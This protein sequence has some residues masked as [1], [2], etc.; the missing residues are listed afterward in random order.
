MYVATSKVVGKVSVKVY[1]DTKHFRDNLEKFLNRWE[2]KQK[3]TIKVNTE[4]NEKQLK[5]EAK[6]KL[7]QLNK[8][9]KAE[10]RKIQF[11][12]EI[13]EVG[14][15]GSVKSA[16]KNLQKQASAWSKAHPIKFA[17]ELDVIGVDVDKAAM[18]AVE[19]KLKDWVNDLTPLKVGIAPELILGTSAYVTARLTYL[20]RPR[21]VA[22][23]PVLNGL[24]V[25]KVATVL[26]AL[27][28]GRAVWN[29]G[30]SLISG[31]K[32]LDKA[33]PKIAAVSTALINLAGY[34]MAAGSNIVSLG[35]SLASIAPVVLTLPGIFGGIAVG[36]GA[37]YAA[38][39]DINTVLPEVADQFHEMQDVI[40]ARFW[41]QAEAPMRR[42]FGTMMPLFTRNLGNTGDALGTF[43]AQLSDS[44][45]GGFDNDIDSMF[46]SLNESIQISSTYTEHF[47]GVIATLGRVGSASLPR[48]AEWFGDTAESFDGWL[49]KAEKDGR[50]Q[51]WIDTG[52]VALSD[53]GVVLRETG[54]TLAGLYR[55]MERAGGSTLSMLADTME[56]VSDT[57]NAPKFQ[58]AMTRAFR[59]AHEAMSEIA[60][61]SGP[62]FEGLMVRLS[63]VLSDNLPTAGRIAGKALGAVFG[64]LDQ[65][66]VQGAVTGFFDKIEEAVDNLAPAMPELARAL[67]SV[68]DVIGTVAVSISKVLAPVIEDLGPKVEEVANIIEPFAEFLGDV[69]GGA[70]SGLTGLLSKLP[71]ELLL[72]GGALLAMRRSSFSMSEG[73]GVVSSQVTKARAGITTF[74]GHIRGFGGDLRKMSGEYGRVNRVQSVMLSGLSNTTGA[75][76]RTRA[77]MGKLTMGAGGIAALAAVSSGAADNMGLSNTAMMGMMG[78]MAGPWGAAVGAGIGLVMDMSSAFSG[79]TESL[80]AA[81]E[82]MA[83]TSVSLADKFKSVETA[84]NGVYDTVQDMSDTTGVGDFFNDMIPTLSYATDEL[85]GFNSELDKG[86]D[87][88]WE[89]SGQVGGLANALNIASEQMGQGGLS[90]FDEF[91]DIDD[92]KESVDLFGA[93]LAEVQRTLTQL[94]PAMEYLGYTTEDLMDAFGDPNP[95]ALNDKMAEIVATSQRLDSVAGR[96]ELVSKAFQDLGSSGDTAAMSAQGLDAA[97][98][99]LLNPQ[100]NATQAAIQWREALRGLNGEIKDTQDINGFTAAADENKQSL[101][102][103]VQNLQSVITTNAAAG[104]GQRQLTRRLEEGRQAIIDQSA[105][106]REGRQ[107]VR[108]FLTTMGLTPKLIKSTLEVAGVDLSTKKLRD[109]RKIAQG[110][111]R[112]LQ[113]LVETKGFPG[114]RKQLKTLVDLYDEYPEDVTAILNVQSDKALRRTQDLDEQ[115]EALTDG[116]WVSEV[117]IKDN[118]TGTRKKAKDD[119]VDID[120]FF[121]RPSMDVTDRASPILNIVTQKLDNID[122]RTANSY[123]YTHY[124]T[125]GTPRGPSGDP[126][127]ERTLPT[128]S[129]SVA[130]TQ[131]ALR[132]VENMFTRF[133]DMVR[134]Q[135]VAASNKWMNKMRQKANQVNNA[136]ANKIEQARN[137]LQNADT[138]EERA[139]A[140]RRLRAL[141]K[142]AQGWRDQGKEIDKAV[143]KYE[144]VNQK[145]QEAVAKLDALKQ[146]IAAYKDALKSSFEGWASILNAPMATFSS[147]VNH[148]KRRILDLQEFKDGMADL[149][150]MGLDQT[151]ID[152]LAQ[153]GPDAL[154]FIQSIL[155]QGQAGVDELNDLWGQVDDISLGASD[156][157]GDYQFADELQSAEDAVDS[158]LHTLQDLQGPINAAANALL[159]NIAKGA[160]RNRREIVKNVD[161]IIKK[162]E[163]LLQMM[164]QATQQNTPG[165]HRMVTQTAKST[166]AIH[167]DNRTFHININSQGRRDPDL[168]A[169]AQSVK[170]VIASA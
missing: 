152:Q 46:S 14:L 155:A 134:N 10:G 66:R 137:R 70:V 43:F 82:A 76:Q 95:Q 45:T 160:K 88:V 77:A 97:L 7:L 71:P 103:M 136:I 38:L 141:Q 18:T 162:Y 6:R 126:T 89:L 61:H 150:S 68:V 98:S 11:Q 52:I 151:V 65:T 72:V 15:S 25:T 144:R 105:S 148:L 149:T 106:T 115:L 60:N 117:E 87:K 163:H 58:S 48:L 132:A 3:L 81:D 1:P 92:P 142:L 29:M 80:D 2:S 118:S 96:T 146:E 41:A 93:N 40:S 147:M 161:R 84:V 54:S 4:V 91:M 44:F 166:G 47:A 169:A 145:L 34:A 53:L 56:S 157:L 111:P 33:V 114:T 128:P 120:R 86:A 165:S 12:A 138:K 23:S 121:A 75:A 125:T 167:N 50:L 94:T 112:K 116:A 69:L 20:T 64:A 159:N 73:M 36:M 63:D 67:A 154:A 51:G 130:E 62:E 31:L 108:E 39:K 21:T 156:L 57:V 99:A 113:T 74:G 123:V 78:L 170:A 164:N 30:D 100:M 9:L 124:R 26:A 83:D 101:I 135:L 104:E 107:A 129:K 90:F 22:I 139:A 24:A 143:K 28:G 153:A 168:F 35:G 109:F 131:K 127:S 17:G 158:F 79:M 59:G 133:S 140:K 37:T 19:R 32:D 27:S 122:G 119:L 110:L 102:G 8:T 55:A 85:L 5:L 16:R 13:S 42:F 49:N